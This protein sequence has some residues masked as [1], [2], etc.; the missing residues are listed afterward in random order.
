MKVTL[1]TAFLTPLLA[2]TV[3]L[4]SNRQRLPSAC[5]IA[6]AHKPDRSHQESVWD[7]LDGRDVVNP[8]AI[9]R[10]LI[11]PVY[12]TIAGHASRRDILG[13]ADIVGTGFLNLVCTRSC[14]TKG[15]TYISTDDT[16]NFEHP[17]GKCLCD[18]IGEA[19]KGARV[20]A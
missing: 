6:E 19:V 16:I 15:T 18:F 11:S 10:E 1:S 7:G 5:V 13:V 4:Q 3:M 2:V 17:E 12:A 9:K 20:A 14:S 8:G